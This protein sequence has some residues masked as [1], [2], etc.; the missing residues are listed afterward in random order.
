MIQIGHTP[1]PDDAFMFYYLAEKCNKDTGIE[2]VVED[3][4]SLNK[5]VI[6]NGIDCSAIS[7]YTY[8]KVSHSYDLLSVGAC[9]GENYGPV[10]VKK[11]I[12]YG[13]L[14]EVVAV[15][16]EH[17]TSF[18]LLKIYNSNF[19]TVNCPFERI[20]RLVMDEKIKYGLL[21]HEMQQTYSEFGLEKVVDL[22]EYWFS[23]TK[24]PL[25]LGCIVIR[26]GLPYSVKTAIKEIIEKSLKYSLEHRKEALD[27][28]MKFARFTDRK[29]TE[30]FIGKYVKDFSLNITGDYKKAINTLCEI[31][32][33]RK[34]VD[35]K[36]EVNIF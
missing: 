32:F 35:R 20:P 1:D 8:F 19:A 11:K 29:D 23:L 34:L 14:K 31:A 33:S 15:P 21:I 5:K 13:K 30:D 3:I 16:G 9:F 12:I 24:L 2:L 28:A 22:G 26:K 27:Y 6:M 10:L 18:L 4:E 36:I 17:T 25:P 7:F